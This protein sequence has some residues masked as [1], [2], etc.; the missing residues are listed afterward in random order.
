M[1][2]FPNGFPKVAR[3]L[4]SDDSFGM[5][6]KFGTL[7]SR[8][9]LNKQDEVSKMEAKLEAMDKMDNEND[10]G[11]RYLMSRELDVD[12]PEFPEF[13]GESRVQ[14]MERL[15]KKILEYGELA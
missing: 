14:L 11:K 7:H 6:R 15:E 8:L 1:E 10:D 5:Y 13:W 3:F 9:L 2:D 12:R 4:D